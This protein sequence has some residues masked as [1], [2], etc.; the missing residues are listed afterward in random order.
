[1]LKLGVGI[2]MMGWVMVMVVVAGGTA[3]GTGTGS[4]GECQL[5]ENAAGLPCAIAKLAEKAKNITHNHDYKD[6]DETW[7]YVA[8]HKEQ[9]NT[10]ST[11]LQGEI[12]TAKRRGTLT[13]AEGNKLIQVALDAQNKTL[14]EHQKADTA[15]KSHNTTYQNA[16]HSTATALGDTRIQGNCHQTASLLS[17]LQCHVKGTTVDSA[18][19]SVSTLCE[20]KNHYQDPSVSTLLKL[21]QNFKKQD[22]VQRHRGRTQSGSGEV[23]HYGQ[24]NAANGSGGPPAM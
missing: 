14:E 4:N 24:E 3:G 8:P 5:N 9:A 1:M 2:G 7:G 11:T 18:S 19:A 10:G 15:F 6:I 12:E 13:K 17:I 23:E 16:H 21:P 22:V 20:G